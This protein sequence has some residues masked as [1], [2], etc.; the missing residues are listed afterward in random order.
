[1]LEEERRKR[2][3]FERVQQEKEKQLRG[4]FEIFEQ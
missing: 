1:M 3:E 2:E 4:K